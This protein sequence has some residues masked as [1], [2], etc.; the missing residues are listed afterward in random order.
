M[1]KQQTNKLTTII[2]FYQCDNIASELNN[3]LFG[4]IK[5]IFEH[6][7]TF[8]IMIVIVFVMVIT[9]MLK[10]QTNKRSE[11]VITKENFPEFKSLCLDYNGAFTFGH[12]PLYG[13]IKKVNIYVPTK[14]FVGATPI[15]P[16]DFFEY[17]SI[18]LR[19]AYDS[20]SNLIFK[21]PSMFVVN[22]S[23]CNSVNLNNFIPHE[24]PM[25]TGKNVVCDALQWYDTFFSNFSF[26]I[27]YNMIMHID[28]IYFTIFIH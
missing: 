23:F 26:F 3:S 9:M 14:Y 7:N 5:N 10:Q 25:L 12:G 8:V 28:L 22:L 27:L 16:I 13:P 4:Q 11:S 19:I 6:D 2:D 1:L 21:I 24:N 20:S 17:G 15:Q 18:Q